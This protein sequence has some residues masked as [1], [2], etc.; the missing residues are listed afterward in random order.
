MCMDW[1]QA[2]ALYMP[3]DQDQNHQNQSDQIS[4]SNQLG[5]VPKAESAEMPAGLKQSAG[6]FLRQFQD[7]RAIGLVVFLF[8]ALMVTWSGMQVIQT[9]YDLQKQISQ[10]QQENQVQE[11][12]NN[13]LKLENQY[14]NTDQYL[15]LKARQDFGLGSPGEKLVIVPRD[16]ALA[17]TTKDVLDSGVPSAASKK[18]QYQKNFEA[19]INFFLHRQGEL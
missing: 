4:P 2:Q 13:N 15:E 16:V 8:I 9:N 10:L 1:L 17:H 12:A 3:N 7:V 18:P 5:Q 19:W 14:F 6:K 11:L